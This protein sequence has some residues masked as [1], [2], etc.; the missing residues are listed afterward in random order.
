MTG[1]GAPGQVAG[2]NAASAPPQVQFLL[3][4]LD[5]FILRIVVNSKGAFLGQLRLPLSSAPLH[6]DVWYDLGA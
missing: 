6:Q 2:Y 1:G 3:P 4:Q 5:G